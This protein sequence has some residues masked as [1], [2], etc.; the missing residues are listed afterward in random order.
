M[1]LI[2]KGKAV[3]MVCHRLEVSLF[4]FPSSYLASNNLAF[5]NCIILENKD[6]HCCDELLVMDQG[7][8]KERGSPRGLLNAVGGLFA[9]MMKCRTNS[10]I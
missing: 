10:R 1:E 8:I 4:L 6:I 9:S 7:L 5:A 3:L 2:K